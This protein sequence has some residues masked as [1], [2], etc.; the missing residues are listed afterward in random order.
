[1][2]SR[3]FRPCNSCDSSHVSN[4]ETRCYDEKKLIHILVDLM[5]GDPIEITLKQSKN[6]QHNG[7]YLEFDKN[8]R[9]IHFQPFGDADVK[10]LALADICTIRYS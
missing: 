9:V 7:Y 4:R 6:I 10:E 8:N 2:S 5:M 1:M 3:K